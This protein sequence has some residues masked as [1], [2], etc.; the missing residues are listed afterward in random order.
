MVSLTPQPGATAPVTLT[1]LSTL[2]MVGAN[3]VPAAG[4]LFWDWNIGDVLLLGWAEAAVIGIYALIKVAVIDRL[5]FLLRGPFVAFA[6]AFILGFLLALVL[7]ISHEVNR[8]VTG[9]YQP[10]DFAALARGLAP[11][12]AVFVVSH[13]VSFV[14]D[15]IGRGEYL[16]RSSEEIGLGFFRHVMPL[17][18]MAM[19]ASFIVAVFGN[20]GVLFLIVILLK[21][22]SEILVH[23]HEHRLKPASV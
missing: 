14:H 4:L 3:V 8:L 16:N 1:S 21:L 20:V 13:G 9:T 23:L 6:F 12:L 17:L 15:F 19:T 2:T 18:L 5:V 22:S 11:A 10:Q 7:M